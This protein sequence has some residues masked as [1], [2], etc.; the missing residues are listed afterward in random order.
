MLWRKAHLCNV[1]TS[2]VAVVREV[3]YLGYNYGTVLTKD[4][5]LFDPS[6]TLIKLRI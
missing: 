5:D 6:E 4:F 3:H 1:S 2:R